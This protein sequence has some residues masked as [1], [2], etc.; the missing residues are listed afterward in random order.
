MGLGDVGEIMAVEVAT[1][2]FESVLSDGRRIVT[3]TGYSDRVRQMILN[4]RSGERKTYVRGSIDEF[5][6][7]DFVS[8]VVVSYIMRGPGGEIEDFWVNSWQ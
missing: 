6:S 5:T 8:G 3:T 2:T 7:D 4:R 1:Y